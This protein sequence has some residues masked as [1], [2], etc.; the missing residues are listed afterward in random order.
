MSYNL[1][2]SDK[3]TG[4]H[5]DN[6]LSMELSKTRAPM[7]KEGTNYGAVETSNKPT[8]GG[9]VNFPAEKSG[10]VGQPLTLPLL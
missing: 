7:K 3:R 10:R 5:H 6:A 2:W 4:K 1:Q 8:K 9:R